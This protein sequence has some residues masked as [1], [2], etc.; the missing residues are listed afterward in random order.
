[1]KDNSS[2]TTACYSFDNSTISSSSI[3]GSDITRANTFVWNGDTNLVLHDNNTKKIDLVEEIKEIREMLLMINRDSYLEKK[4][5]KLK[6]A[7]DEYHRQL[8]KY[9][10]F[11]KL[12][13]DT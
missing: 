7:A 3:S 1:M 6:E 2:S 10:T 5:P 13:G 11:E 8:E 9:K 12:K 4:Y